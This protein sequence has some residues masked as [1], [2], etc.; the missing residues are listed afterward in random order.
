MVNAVECNWTKKEAKA[1]ITFLLAEK[2]RHE[3]DIR[4]IEKSI[5]LLRRKFGITDEDMVECEDFSQL[6][7]HF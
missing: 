4:H 5:Q 6:F 1:L 7:L 2:Q 3:K